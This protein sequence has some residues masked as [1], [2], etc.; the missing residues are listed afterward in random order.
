M[1]G[2]RMWTYPYYWV[3][4]FKDKAK[5]WGYVCELILNTG[6]SLRIKPSVGVTYMNLSLL[7]GSNFTDKAKCWGHVCGPILTTGISL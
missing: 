4:H 2:S 5:C 3:L 1:L 7:L 6:I